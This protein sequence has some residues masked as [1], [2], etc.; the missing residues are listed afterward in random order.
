MVVEAPKAKSGKN[1]RKE[2][3][4]YPDSLMLL[5]W[6]VNGGSMKEITQLDYNPLISRT[7]GHKGGRWRNPIASARTNRKRG[8][9]RWPH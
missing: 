5:N 2:H 3:D 8:G 9:E 1:S 4:D 7:G 6:L